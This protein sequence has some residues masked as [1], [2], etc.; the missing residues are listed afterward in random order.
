MVQF[1]EGQIINAQFIELRGLPALLKMAFWQKGRFSTRLRPLKSPKKIIDKSNREILM[2]LVSK[3]HE[4]EN[5]IQQLPELS[6][7]IVANPLREKQNLSPLQERILE[8]CQDPVNISDLLM[9]LPDAN[10]LILAEV[11]TLLEHRL[12]G[13]PREIKQLIYE[14]EAMGGFGKLVHSLSSMFKKKKD[15]P[16]YRE[17]HPTLQHPEEEVS[18]QLRVTIPPLTKDQVATINQRLEQYLS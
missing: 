17:T 5:L 8:T 18:P 14:K 2:L 15:D 13:T 4:W 6:Q 10:E 1:L 16:S 7:K 3:L 12:V 11:Q 9:R